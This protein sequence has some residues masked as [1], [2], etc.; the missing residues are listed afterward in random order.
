MICL[1]PLPCA[2]ADDGDLV[3]ARRRFEAH[4]LRTSEPVLERYRFVGRGAARMMRDVHPA[5]VAELRFIVQLHVWERTGT[6]AAAVVGV[7][8]ASVLITDLIRR[9]KESRGDYIRSE[10]LAPA[11]GAMFLWWNDH[12]GRHAPEHLGADVLVAGGVADVVVEEL[13]RLVWSLR[14]SGTRQN[15][16]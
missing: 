9:M 4:V 13:A 6:V 12:C 14:R 5:Y 2:V 1:A 11:V 15:K 16:E 10:D 3:D 8:A 7:P